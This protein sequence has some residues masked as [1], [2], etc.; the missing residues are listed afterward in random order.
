MVKVKCDDCDSTGLCVGCHGEGFDMTGDPD[1]GIAP[2]ARCEDCAGS[3]ECPGCFDA[4]V[5]ESMATS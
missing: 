4:R 3:G 2:G 1:C 5:V